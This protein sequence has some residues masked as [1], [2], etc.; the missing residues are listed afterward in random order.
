MSTDI[1]LE[2]EVVSKKTQWYPK[3]L[4]HDK[5]AKHELERFSEEHYT[6]ITEKIVNISSKQL[7]SQNDNK[8]ELRKT[9]Q[10][11]FTALLS[12]QIV[13]VIALVA[14]NASIPAFHISDNV[15]IT[16][17]TAVFLETLGAVIAMVKFAFNSE[18]EVQILKIMNSVISGFQKFNTVEKT[19][20]N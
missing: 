6:R 4:P 14:C 10:V 19:L 3:E 16:L 2:Q 18:Q 11:F 8:I 17:M 20:H 7:E 9:F 15:L 5:D 1:V 13:S 12:F